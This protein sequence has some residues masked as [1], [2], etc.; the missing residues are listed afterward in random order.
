MRTWNNLLGSDFLDAFGR[1]DSSAECPCER[2]RS[3]SVVQALHLMN[4]PSLHQRMASGKSVPALLAKPAKE[5]E[6][7]APEKI[8][9]DIYL[10]TY[11]RPPV[12]EELEIAKAHFATKDLKPEDAAR[13]LLWSLI[14]SAEFVFNH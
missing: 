3:S 8:I 14:N 12:K 11:A 7:V 9:A 13:D 10:A 5:G 4:S 2:D 1:P 6:L